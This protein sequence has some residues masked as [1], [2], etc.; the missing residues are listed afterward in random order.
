MP[1]S[2]LHEFTTRIDQSA[3]KS[4]YVKPQSSTAKDL[5]PCTATTALSRT[6][7][8]GSDESEQIA[9]SE[10]WPSSPRL[11]AAPNRLPS[12]T[13]GST[14]D[15]SRHQQGIRA[16]ESDMES[17][18]SAGSPRKRQKMFVEK[19]S[20]NIHA[21]S[22]LNSARNHIE[23]A[24]ADHTGDILPQEGSYQLASAIYCPP[25]ELINTSQR[26]HKGLPQLKSPI[27]GEQASTPGNS[28]LVI[29]LENSTP[30]SDSDLET[31]LPQPLGNRS[32][33]LNSHDSP[34]QISVNGKVNK[35]SVL[36]VTRTPY[37]V[38]PRKQDCFIFGQD[39]DTS[40]VELPALRSKLPTDLETNIEALSSSS[41]SQH[42]TAI[43]KN[44]SNSIQRSPAQDLRKFHEGDMAFQTR[45]KSEPVKEFSISNQQP[46]TLQPSDSM[47]PQSKFPLHTDP[48][49]TS[50][51]K[52]DE[53][54][55]AFPNVTNR[56]K[57]FRI[58][59]KFGF[60]QLP[61]VTE[62]PKAVF[63]RQR[64]DFIASR[65]LEYKETESGDSTE[66]DGHS[67]E[68][69]ITEGEGTTSYS[70]IVSP[71]TQQVEMRTDAS[72]SQAGRHEVSTDGQETDGEETRDKARHHGLTQKQDPESTKQSI[73][74]IWGIQNWQRVFEGGHYGPTL[75]DHAQAFATQCDDWAIAAQYILFVFHERVTSGMR[76]AAPKLIASD[77]YQARVRYLR[78]VVDP[79]TFITAEQLAQNPSVYNM[80]VHLLPIQR[81]SIQT[82]MS[83]Q[84]LLIPD[85]LNHNRARQPQ[86]K[87]LPFDENLSDSPSQSQSAAPMVQSVEQRRQKDAQRKNLRR[88]EKRKSA[89]QILLQ[90]LTASAHQNEMVSPYESGRDLEGV[91]E[92]AKQPSLDLDVHTDLPNRSDGEHNKAPGEVPQ[93][94][95]VDGPKDAA[96]NQ[97]VS[98]TLKRESTPLSNLTQRSLFDRFKQA[99]SDYTGDENL[100]LGMCRNID[101]LVKENRMEHR[102]LWDDFIVRRSTE[103]PQYLLRCSEQADNPMPYEKFYREEVE[104]PIHTKKIVTPASLQEIIQS[105]EQPK[106][107]NIH[108]T[109]Q[110][111]SNSRLQIKSP[112]SARNP[113]NL[114]SVVDPPVINLISEADTVS[115]DSEPVNPTP[116]RRSARP[117]LLAT[118][119]KESEHRSSTSMTS[120]ESLR[121]KSPQYVSL[122]KVIAAR[123]ESAIYISPYKAITAP[124]GSS[125]RIPTDASSI[126]APSRPSP[127]VAHAMPTMGVAPTI[128]SDLPPRVD[129]HPDISPQVRKNSCISQN[130]QKTSRVRL[131]NTYRPPHPLNPP[132]QSLVLNSRI[133]TQGGPPQEWFRDSNA[134]FNEFVRVYRATKAGNG[135]SFRRLDDSAAGANVGTGRAEAGEKREPQWGTGVSGWTL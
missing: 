9:N 38:V 57:N 96:Y 8:D 92:S 58:T 16:R 65:R 54:G 115:S 106:E 74:A 102:S 46:R 12:D 73:I 31:S 135:N 114:A 75:L 67:S 101:N 127:L 76:E 83:P 50:K 107:G 81:E 94:L 36:Q 131:Q 13:P 11:I 93:A 41:V 61:P 129:H 3:A 104:E 24:D 6:D 108:S 27:I 77:V 98:P 68:V 103:Y 110:P 80:A 117:R 123:S 14:A 71:S 34:S 72:Y 10:E 42:H 40:P 59:K 60:S 119:M 105:R 5:P 130:P 33:T 116:Y 121:S 7:S 37:S 20:D 125:V 2:V 124:T 63:Q 64:R 66:V 111:L 86:L 21:V 17:P 28:P 23:Y 109:P 32:V 82:G 113:S 87:I 120:K 26:L 78:R 118:R 62:D 30:G 133:Q 4:L 45:S 85:T 22:P 29:N 90:K 91:S 48:R 43:D 69:S 19:G 88:D 44:A 39:N 1:S 97:T 89:N 35:E 122:D 112:S 47:P 79:I 15:H 84:E 95:A 70:G 18:H 25:S 55:A 52:A 99:Y 56:K 49:P 100:F 134:P 128:L 53:S 132:S 126:Q 51:R